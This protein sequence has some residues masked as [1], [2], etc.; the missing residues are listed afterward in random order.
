MNG[1]M[2]ILDSDMNVA[3][4]GVGMDYLLKGVRL[5]KVQTYF[6]I[7]FAKERVLIND[8]DPL[9]GTIKSGGEVYSTGISLSI[10][11]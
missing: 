4:A 6:Q 7:H 9:F 1:E 8:R 5:L 10:Q 3:S 11:L 2:N